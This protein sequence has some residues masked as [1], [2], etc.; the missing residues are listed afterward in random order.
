MSTREP[1]DGTFNT[2]AAGL[3]HSLALRADGSL[4]G[5]GWN[6]YGQAQAPEGEFTTMAGGTWHSVALRRN[7]TLCG[8][9]KNEFGECD[10]PE[11]DD[12]IAVAA[13]L[14]NSLA[15]RADGSLVGWGRNAF[16]K[17]ELSAD[18]SFT[19]V[20]ATDRFSVGLR[21]DGSLAVWG[22]T[23]VCGDVP[24][25]EYVAIDGGMYHAI[26]LA[27]DGT[28]AFW[29]HYRMKEVTE[30]PAT[31]D[32]TAISAGT[33][34]SL[35]LREDGS[36]DAWGF[37]PYGVLKVLQG[38]G[39]VSVAGGGW[40]SLA[41]HEDGTIAQWGH[42]PEPVSDTEPEWLRLPE[43]ATVQTIY[44]SGVPHTDRQ[45]RVMM[46]YD[47]QRSF[48]PIGI[49]SGRVDSD[50]DSLKAAGYNCI[51][52][53]HVSDEEAVKLVAEHDLQLIWQGHGG[54]EFWE[55]RVALPG[56]DRDRLLA[57]YSIDEPYVFTGGSGKTRSDPLDE[58][59]KG[60][61]SAYR[62]NEQAAKRLLP[63][64]PVFVNMS[65]VPDAPQYGWG[66]WIHRS[67]IASLDNY[68]F[69][70]K[71]VR[72][73]EFSSPQTGVPRTVWA[74]ANVD[75]QT[76]PV[77]YIV[78]AFEQPIATA[79]LYFRFPTP[80]ELRAAVYGGIIHGAT[81]I[82]Y[83]AWD[84]WQARGG[85]VIGMEKDP[86]GDPEHPDEKPD[87]ASI[88]NSTQLIQSR[89]LWQ[90]AAQINHELRELTPVI[91]APTVGDEVEYSATVTTGTTQ[92]PPDIRSLLKP[93][94]DGGYVLLSV[95]IDEG[96]LNVD[97]TFPDLSSVELLYENRQDDL[98]GTG[99]GVA[100]Q[101]DETLRKRTFTAH[102]QPYDVH[103]FRIR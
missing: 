21:R 51:Q 40:H 41:V 47:P 92:T 63:D 75:S 1:P 66:K 49:Y 62:T 85:Q 81:G 36:L 102:Y 89:A 84:G 99:T 17:L 50:Y 18:H 97:W 48:L 26:A 32:V 11:G 93:H 77:W 15:V 14:E 101:A 28:I 60:W 55:K 46:E 2:V 61:Q 30:Q 103:V 35:T 57:N 4:V 16:G 71:G 65:P 6:D 83:F 52:A 25:G 87:N 64:L 7:G 23:D 95:N 22:D 45:G 10:A 94:P 39:F 70:H 91:L 44:R 56:F 24:D 5:W 38:Q 79:D 80:N 31:G 73:S 27:A 3:Y 72:F 88:A 53:P 67:D 74:A 59:Q 13:G 43:P 58:I 37:A 12:F 19:A 68:P 98:A 8:F 33:H 82:I 29:G 54:D 9:G 34:H 20:A 90:T 42:I 78:P 76:K 86:V 96:V 69:K 100:A